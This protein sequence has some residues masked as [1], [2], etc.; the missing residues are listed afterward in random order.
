MSVFLY[1]EI[2]LTSASTRG[3]KGTNELTSAKIL[4]CSPLTCVGLGKHMFAV[5]LV[6]VHMG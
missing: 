4:C 3:Q 5:G 2:L 6:N 1:T